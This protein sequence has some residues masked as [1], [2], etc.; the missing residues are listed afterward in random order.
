M[1][2]RN[3]FNSVFFLHSPHVAIAPAK[4]PAAHNKIV[5][6][7]SAATPIVITLAMEC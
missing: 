7:K 3:Y 1:P 5:Q 2:L 6:L 4:L